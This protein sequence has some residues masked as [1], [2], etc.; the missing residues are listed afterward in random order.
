MGGSDVE[1]D[2]QACQYPRKA[3][4]AVETLV[5][6]REEHLGRDPRRPSE[7]L[8]EICGEI[9]VFP[10]ESGEYL[11]AKVGLGETSL[12]A[13]VGPECPTGHIGDTFSEHMGDTFWL[14]RETR[15]ALEGVIVNA[16]PKLLI[17]GG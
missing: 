5:G 1:A 16:G 14:L 10:H 3:D 13:A 4:F 11:V 15:N 8:R 7:A 12:K 6:R 17:H 2:R 9:A